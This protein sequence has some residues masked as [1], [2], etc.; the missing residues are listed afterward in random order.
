[1]SALARIAAG[2][3]AEHGGGEADGTSG[4]GSIMRLAPLP[5]RYVAFFSDRVG[6]LGRYAAESRAPTHPSPECLAACRY[7]ALVLAA[8]LH[9][10]DRDEVLSPRW[11]LLA[12]LHAAERLD[13]SILEVAQG[14]F[15]RRHPPEIRGSGFVVKSLEA[16]L[17]A[18][19]RASS[20]RD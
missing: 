4:N 13:P 2:T 5:V 1:R 14:S 19:H 16:A 6:T 11:P 3:P 7:L 10:L 18:F 17:W 12:E 15:R 20:F 8:L 9:G